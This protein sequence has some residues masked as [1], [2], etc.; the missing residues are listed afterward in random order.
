M[1]TVEQNFAAMIL[2][3][4]VSSGSLCGLHGTG[5]C[6]A[7]CTGLGTA[8]RTARDWGLQCRLRH[9]G[10]GVELSLVTRVV[11][12]A[13]SEPPWSSRQIQI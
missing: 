11:K 7:N 3:L 1:E 12:I 5:D 8:V 10:G 13:R 2:S 9:V 4:S 6:S